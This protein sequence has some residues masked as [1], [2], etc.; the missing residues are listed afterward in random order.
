MYRGRLRASASSSSYLNTKVLGQV[1]LVFVCEEAGKW[2]QV[3]DS[4]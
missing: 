4:K 1:A 3:S 2:Q